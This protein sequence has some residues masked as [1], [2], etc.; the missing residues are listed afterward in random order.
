LFLLQEFNITIKD[1]SGREN[2]VA[3][4][5]SRVPKI[6]NSLTVEYQFPDKHLFVF[7]IKMPWYADVVNYLA[8]GKFLAHLSSRERKLIV[9]HRARFTWIGGYLFH[10]RS[11]IQIQRCIRDDEIHDVLKACHDEPCG[12]HFAYRRIGHKVLQMGYYWPLIFKDAK[13]YVQAYDK[14]QRMGRPGQD[15]E[16]P[17]QPQVVMEPFERWALDFFGPFNPKSNQKA[18]ILVATDYMTKWVEE[19]ALPNT[20]E[21]VVIKFIF[22]LFIHY[23]LPMEIITDRGSQFTAHKISTTLCNYHIK[24][25]VTSPYHPQENGQVESTNKVLEEILTK[26]VSTNRQNCASELPNSLW[27][28]RTTWRHTTR[29]S[30]YHLVFG[31]EL[32]F[33]IEFDIKTLRMA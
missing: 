12:G 8:V 29:Y 31:K 5:L 7:T 6:D 22:E 19:V 24:H 4:F 33:P 10:T 14:F 3:D 30:P 11:D 23:G 1:R 28:Y 9:Q 15:D 17:L 26:I 27:A 13:K 32:I 2:L 20:T 25:R 21:E 16:M 18:Y